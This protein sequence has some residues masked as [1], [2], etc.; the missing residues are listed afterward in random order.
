M[1]VIAIAMAVIV[2][3]AGLVIFYVAFPHRGETPAQG[4]WLGDVM[5]R[6]V[7][8][9]PTIEAADQAAHQPHEQ[10][11]DPADRPSSTR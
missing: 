1:L 6:A 2:L 10:P 9:L 4:E 8:S 3:L 7:G 5:S 11:E